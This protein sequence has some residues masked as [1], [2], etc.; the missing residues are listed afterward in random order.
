M[1]SGSLASWHLNNVRDFHDCTTHMSSTC[2]RSLSNPYQAYHAYM[3]ICMIMLLSW[4]TKQSHL[5]RYKKVVWRLTFISK[6]PNN[7]EVIKWKHFPHYWP[8]VR[9]IHRSPQR[10]VTWSFDILFHLRLNKRLSK[11][12]KGWWFETPSRSL[13]R[14]CNEYCMNTGK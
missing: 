6:I 5:F 12:S 2:A 3:I 10:L 1:K 7:D 13:W 9:G 14:H 4:I 8:F 11:Q